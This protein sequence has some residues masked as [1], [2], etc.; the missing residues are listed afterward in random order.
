MDNE[1]LAR[2]VRNFKQSDFKPDDS[3]LASAINHPAEAVTRALRFVKN[4]MD[5]A[6]GVPDPYDNPYPWLAPTVEQRAEA[7]NNLAG[8]VQT[9][10]FASGAAPKSAGGTLGT[11]IGP[12][13]K[14]WDK[15]A[16]KK[17]AGLLRRGVDPEKVWQRHMTGQMPDGA[18]FQEIPDN[19]AVFNLQNAPLDAYGAQ[20]LPAFEALLHP[21]LQ[22]SYPQLNESKMLHFP[23]EEFKG[24]SFDPRDKSI[25]MGQDAMKEGKSVSLHEL[26][27]AI[28]DREGWARGGNPEQFRPQYEKDLSTLKTYHSVKNDVNDALDLAIASGD[29]KRVN[30]QMET[31]GVIEKKINDISKKIA[32]HP[33]ESYKRLAGEAQARETQARM[34]MNM[35]ERR[36]NYPLKGG[37][38]G[39]IPLEE[40][41]FKYGDNGPAM[42]LP[43]TEFSRAHAIAQQNAALPIEQGGLGLPAN[44]TAMERARAMGFDV[45]N[46][47]YH[48]T[49]NNFNEF[50][51]N[52]IGH[53]HDYSFGFHT[54]NNPNEASVYADSIQNAGVKFNPK[55]EL[56]I[57][58][59]KGG[60]VLPLYARTENPL[61]INSNEMTASMEADFNRAEI[62]DQLIKAKRAGNIH[63][64][65]D[66]SAGKADWKNRNF[67]ALKPE[68]LRSRFAAFDPMKKD[69]ANI[70]ASTLLGMGL[71]KEF[72]NDDTR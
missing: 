61:T 65:V 31:L 23:D 60:N 16:A 51:K 28:Q 69:S 67:I 20:E 40:L 13:A 70:L 26:Q 58:L 49:D 18:L 29:E 24:A 63:D 17:A 56:A 7:A 52:K 35:D 15:E 50:D 25:T 37:K 21:E 42:S 68:L 64:A 48:G 59:R 47:V 14:T 10:A 53:L 66:I 38:I 43:E 34:L 33:E 2:I 12:N 9:G 39:E 8:L 45:D 22:K 57:P 71:A 44:N 6:A 4:N 19:K 46:P 5:T 72:A 55:S 36:A 30:N 62:V 27:H 11:F 1:L 41:I 54:T 32:I 3:V